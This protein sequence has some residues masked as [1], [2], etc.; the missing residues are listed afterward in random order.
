[1]IR[2]L[3]K[4]T[5]ANFTC[6]RKHLQTIIRKR[7]KLEL[8][9][10]YMILIRIVPGNGAK[11]LVGEICVPTYNASIHIALTSNSDKESFEPTETIY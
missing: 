6:K 1:M 10:D 4:V 7:V 2:L 8:I 3:Q 9:I 11:N 5:F